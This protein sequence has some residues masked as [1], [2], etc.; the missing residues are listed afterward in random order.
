MAAYV[1]KYATKSSG[2]TGVLDRR[3]GGPTEIAL[4][5]ASEDERR[6]IGTC[7]RLGA[8]PEYAHL[9][10]R[11][12]AHMLAYRG[13]VVTKSRHYS[14]TLAALREARRTYR[15]AQVHREGG[16]PDGWGEQTDI[17]GWR[18]AR[19][20]YPNTGDA[21]LAAGVRESL[22]AAREAARIERPRLPA[23]RRPTDSEAPTRRERG[24]P[25]GR[26]DDPCR[27]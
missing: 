26:R 19:S 21:M 24:R 18:F 17:R 25:H 7:W 5:P 13:H 12:W 10:L 1:S 14:T 3:V 22:A 16:D 23:Q 6:L 2:T 8:L 11:A 20:G 27:V 15:A 4:L 9:R